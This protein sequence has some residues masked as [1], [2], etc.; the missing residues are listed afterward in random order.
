MVGQELQNFP[1]IHNEDCKRI[2]LCKNYIE[3]LPTEFTGPKLVSLFLAENEIK[4][5]PSGFLV[6]LTSLKVLDLAG[7]ARITSIPSTVS[8]LKQLEVLRLS[9]LSEIQD[10]TEQI[11]HLSSLQFLYVNGCERLPSLPSKIG[12]LKNLKVLD[13]NECTSHPHEISHLTSLSTLRASGLLMF[14]TLPFVVIRSPVLNLYCSAKS[15]V[16]NL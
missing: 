4:E 2:S 8:E 6:S 7:N 10:L 14:C 3:N 15:L 1:E 9:N 11:C 13:L 16:C 5:L 12:Q